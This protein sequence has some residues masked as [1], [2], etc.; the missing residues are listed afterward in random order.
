M[1]YF[2]TY[3]IELTLVAALLVAI[4]FFGYLGYGLVASDNQFSGDQALAFVQHQ[5]AEGPRVTGSATNERIK[6]WLSNELRVAGWHVVI[7]PFTTSNQTAA[8]NLIARNR[9]EA[10]GTPVILLGSHYNTRNVADRDDNEASRNAPTPGANSNAS[11]TA[12]LLELAKRIK[13]TDLEYRLCLAFF[14]AS[15]N[16]GLEGWTPSEGSHYFIDTL[17]DIQELDSCRN[18][19]A[20]IILDS[21]GSGPSLVFESSSE[22]VLVRMI[23]QAAMENDY[24]DF[25]AG[26]IS[27][28]ESGDHSPFIEAQIPTLYLFN[29]TYTH[30]HKSSDTVDKV[31]AAELEKLG[32]TLQTWLEEFVPAQSE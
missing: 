26:P 10:D 7:Q 1:W 29:D 27:K 17:D 22:P 23:Q 21:V 28:P 15:D 3:S 18:P 11:G 31:S 25:P 4:G 14:D 5:V 6:E 8:V 12:V 2:R 30:L 16:N 19:Q 20:A 9:K 32:R 24:Q 13:P